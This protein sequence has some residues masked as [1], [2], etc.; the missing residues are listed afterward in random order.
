M[1]QHD[2]FERLP[3]IPLG[4][5]GTKTFFYFVRSTRQVRALSPGAH[6]E[7]NFLA[8][9]EEADW[10]RYYLSNPNRAMDWT[11]AGESLMAHCRDVGMNDPSLTRGRGAWIDGN[12]IVF[13][14]GEALYVNGK[15]ITF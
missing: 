1:T 11:A 14:A 15:S 9:A 8:M 2:T 13:H 6:N 10:Q 4:H 3:V 5:T 7:A 12:D